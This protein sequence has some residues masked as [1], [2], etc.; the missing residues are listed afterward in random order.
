MRLSV[1]LVVAMGLLMAAACGSESPRAADEA[2]SPSAMQPD[3][4]SITTAASCVEQ[5]SLEALDK[6]DYAFDGTVK[7]I[8]PGAEPDPDR[9]TFDVH[10]WYR[11]GSGAEAVRRASGFGAITSAGGSQ[12]TTGERLLVAGDDD[13]VWECGFTQPYDA[14]VAADWDER[15]S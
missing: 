12:H 7:S 5:Y 6:R 11:G 13:F 3:S 15:L 14:E 2:A 10:A 9:V 8:E 4:A 1:R